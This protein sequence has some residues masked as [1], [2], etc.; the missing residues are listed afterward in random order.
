MD[1]VHELERTFACLFVKNFPKLCWRGSDSETERQLA[2]PFCWISPIGAS[3]TLGN[4]TTRFISPTM[5]T[6]YVDYPSFVVE[7]LLH[8]QV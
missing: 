3:N 6:G 2:H 1:R 8:T 5:N 4:R 7:V